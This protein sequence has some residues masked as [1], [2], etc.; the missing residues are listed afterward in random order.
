M[1]VN[2]C[3]TSVLL[4]ILLSELHDAY[5]ME[6]AHAQKVLAKL[7]FK[8]AAQTLVDVKE[9]CYLLTKRWFCLHAYNAANVA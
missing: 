5:F 7:R 1:F 6:T 4:R 8:Q 3:F 2:Q 9:V